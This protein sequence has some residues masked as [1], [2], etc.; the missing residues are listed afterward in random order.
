MEKMGKD[1]VAIKYYKKTVKSG[2]KEPYYFAAKAALQIALLY[3]D[4][5]Y[6]SG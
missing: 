1:E 2:F 5:H 4:K 6:K 3:E